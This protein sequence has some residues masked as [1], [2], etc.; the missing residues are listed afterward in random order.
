MKGG[1]KVRRAADMQIPEPTTA[2]PHGLESPVAFHVTQ[3]RTSNRPLLRSWNPRLPCREH[4]GEFPLE[5]IPQGVLAKDAVGGI[6]HSLA[7]NTDPTSGFAYCH[8]K[9]RTA[10]AE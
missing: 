6:S 10:V 5:W 7:G 3:D 1:V 4:S 8:E 2:P 9:G